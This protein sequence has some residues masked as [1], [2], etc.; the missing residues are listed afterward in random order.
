MARKGRGRPGLGGR[1]KK[2]TKLGRRVVP[3][4]PASRLLASRCRRVVLGAQRRRN[5][6]AL[7]AALRRWTI[8]RPP[9]AAKRHTRTRHGGARPLG[10]LIER[11]GQEA[12]ANVVAAF[13]G[14]VV[15]PGAAAWPRGG[16]ESR[17]DGHARLPPT[18]QGA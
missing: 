9:D 2:P 6:G 5:L 15:I 14:A 16:R 1:M 17:K 3:A 11:G 12:P 10:P 13:R 8:R 18:A 7:G 4:A